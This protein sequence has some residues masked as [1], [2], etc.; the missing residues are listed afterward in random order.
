[1]Q[2]TAVQVTA[3]EAAAVAEWLASGRAVHA[4]RDHFSHREPLM[5]GMWGA[6]MA[7]GEARARWNTTWTALMADS[8]SRRGIYGVDQAMLKLHVWPWARADSL[9]HDSYSCAAFPRSVGFPT[10]RRDE[11][12]NF[13]GGAVSVNGHLWR[14]CPKQCRRRGHKDWTHC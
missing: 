11:P 9:Q 10:K 4:M 13:V 12:G 8:N 6:R 3:R 5:A 1:V 2:C 14:V 7:G